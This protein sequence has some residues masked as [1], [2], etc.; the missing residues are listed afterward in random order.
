MQR[1]RWRE[2]NDLSTEIN[3]ARVDRMNARMYIHAP[4]AS[5]DYSGED[6]GPRGGLS[7]A[8]VVT[9]ADLGLRREVTC[10]FSF[11]FCAFA[12]SDGTALLDSND[13]RHME[14]SLCFTSY[15]LLTSRASDYSPLYLIGL[16][17]SRG[18]LKPRARSAR[19]IFSIKSWKFGKCFSRVY[20]FF[21]VIRDDRNIANSIMSRARARFS[22][23]EGKKRLTMIRNAS[24]RYLFLLFFFYK[25]YSDKCHRYVCVDNVLLYTGALNNR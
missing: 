6:D 1:E 3:Q 4:L 13:P 15:G 5:V 24:F 21:Y 20:S 10:S 9:I 12:L 25:I 22:K 11:F 14:T 23:C 7:R 16:G 17:R 18:A 19:L 8:A 2:R